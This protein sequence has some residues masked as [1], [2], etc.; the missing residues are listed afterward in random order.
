MKLVSLVLTI[1][2][3]SPTVDNFGLMG[4]AQQAVL[5]PWNWVVM[6][7]S[8]YTAAAG[9][10]VAFRATHVQE[11]GLVL[12][13]QAV[14]EPC[15]RL[16]VVLTR[17]RRDWPRRPA[18]HSTSRVL[19]VPME[20]G[21]LWLARGLGGRSTT[22]HVFVH[23]VSLDR[24]ADR[25]G[26]ANGGPPRCR[27]HV[28]AV[29]LGRGASLMSPPR[30]P[31]LRILAMGDSITEGVGAADNLHALLGGAS[32]STYA[33][34]LAARLGAS[35][36]VVA[37]HHQ[38]W[39]QAG[40]GGVP[41]F[42]TKD[43]AWAE[44]GC[45]FGR[46]DASHVRWPSTTAA[47]G[48]VEESPPHLMLVNLGT[49]DWSAAVGE[50]STRARLRGA[51]RERLYLWCS[52][53]PSAFLAAASALLPSTLTVLLVPFSGACRRFLATAHRRHLATRPRDAKRAAAEPVLLDLGARAEEGLDP[54]ALNDSATTTCYSAQRAPH[55]CDGIH[56]RAMRHRALGVLLARALTEAIAARIQAAGGCSRLSWPGEVCALARGARVERTHER[57]ARSESE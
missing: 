1:K 13:P 12:K 33:W 14:A 57:Q 19:D 15:M 25:W 11:A 43:D 51:A 38:G 27:L 47:A 20:G 35:L 17:G 4:I 9:A 29:L 34:E 49:N 8:A 31:A 56:P 36:S 10:W 6:N 52:L 41:S 18:A 45:G 16:M 37:N 21:S 26:E 7:S 48:G 28:E 2:L 3:V 5:S 50:Y 55:S 23:S 39:G 54:R 44:S 32:T 46:L 22:V 40:R 30:P 53:V 24:S 42:F